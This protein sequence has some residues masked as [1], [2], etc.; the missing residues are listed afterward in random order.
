MLFVEMSIKWL[1][2]L[3]WYMFLFN[4]VEFDVDF[5]LYD[6]LLV[7]VIYCIDVFIV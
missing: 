6:V 2:L 5:L 7:I 1:Y 4:D 3:L